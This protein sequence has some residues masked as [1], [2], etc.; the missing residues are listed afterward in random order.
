MIKKIFMMLILLMSVVLTT[1]CGG[2]VMNDE[3]IIENIDYELLEDGRTKITISYVDDVSEPAIFYI[4]KGEAGVNGVNGNGIKAITSIQSDDKKNTILH[5]EFTSKDMQPVEVMVPNGVS[6][7]GVETTVDEKTKDTTIIINYSD[8]SKSE[9]FIIPRG[10]KGEAG[11]GIK[12]YQC[13]INEDGSQK[14][15]FTY[16]DGTTSTC[17]VPAPQKGD[18]GKDGNFITAISAYEDEFKYYITF[19]FNEGEPK[20]IDFNKPEKPNT[21]L[22]GLGKPNDESGKDGDFYFDTKAN[23]IYKKTEGSWIIIV[24]L[25]DNDEMYQITFDLNDKDGEGV[26]AELPKGFRNTVFIGRGKYFATTDM[27]LP[28]PTRVGFEFG[29]W[30]TSKTPNINNGTFTDLTPVF[31]NL[32]LYAKW[33]KK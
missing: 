5:I 24:D 32:T 19:V 3:L 1:S 14:L 12:D 16:T 15:V 29:G 22:N 13:T 31:D 33:N 23:S 26:E 11:R 18:T 6:V 17:V 30:Y 4:P 7:S 2:F 9:P 8:G 20:M 27:Q 10:E 25:D 21:W 28:I